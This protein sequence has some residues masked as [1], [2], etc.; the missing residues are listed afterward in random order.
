MQVMMI[1]DMFCHSIRSARR[2]MM[3]KMMIVRR[4]AWV[5][6]ETRPS[7][8]SA[9]MVAGV[10]PAQRSM[11]EPSACEAGGSPINALR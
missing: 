11:G 3:I 5:N 6:V 7:G 4:S 9:V 2:T 1:V 8:A 10:A